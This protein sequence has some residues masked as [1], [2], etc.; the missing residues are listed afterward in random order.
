MRF[1][2]D[3]QLFNVRLCLYA[4]R[5]LSFGNDD[6]MVEII[7][8]DKCFRKIMIMKIIKYVTYAT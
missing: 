1:S 3:H 2:R 8:S 5:T 4:N 7:C 6:N